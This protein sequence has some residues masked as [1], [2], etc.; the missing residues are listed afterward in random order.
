MYSFR[1]QRQHHNTEGCSNEINKQKKPETNGK[2]YCNQC[3]K[4][5][6]S[7]QAL[8]GHKSSHS[9]KKIKDAGSALANDAALE[10][11]TR[12]GLAPNNLTHQCRFCNKSFSSGQALGGHQICHYVQASV[13]E[14]KDLKL[15]APMEKELTFE[16]KLVPK[17]KERLTLEPPP[18]HDKIT[19]LFSRRG[20][21]LYQPLNKLDQIFLYNVHTNVKFLM[22]EAPRQAKNGFYGCFSILDDD[23]DSTPQ[24]S[25]GSLDLCYG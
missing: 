25:L 12:Y 16:F 2:H 23:D 22:P 3:D 1:K 15:L 20:W 21:L 18:D 11:D 5:F 19:I 14:G 7:H 13:P 4:S 6:S 8:G 9:I 24:C 17:T 10:H